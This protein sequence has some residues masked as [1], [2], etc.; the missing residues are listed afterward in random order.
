MKRAFS[1]RQRMTM[2]ISVFLI[3]LL[4]AFSFNIVYTRRASRRRILENVYT[5]T[6]F[7][8]ESITNAMSESAYSA[9]QMAAYLPFRSLSDDPSEWYFYYK[10]LQA[11]LNVLESNNF[12]YANIY[13][14]VYNL[15]QDYY[16]RSSIHPMPVREEKEM[17]SWLRSLDKYP[18]YT[19]Q[20][21]VFDQTGYFIYGILQEDFYIGVFLS[22]SSIQKLLARSSPK[23]TAFVVFDPAGA[24]VSADERFSF[25]E[26]GGTVP[27]GWFLDAPDT[28]KLG[29]ENYTLQVY[30]STYGFSVISAT[31][32]PG[33]L[34]GALSESPY[35][36]L[37]PGCLFL[38]VPI[39]Y[40]FLKQELIRPLNYL[41]F[42]FSR[43]ASGDLTFRGQQDMFSVEFNDVIAA[44]NSMLRQIRELRMNYYE[45]KILQ[46]QAENRY[47]RTISYPHFLLNNL[48]LINNFAYEKNEEGIHAAVMNLSSYLRYFITAD[49]SSHTLK[50]DVESARC[51]LN[52]NCLAYPD[53]ISYRFDAEED[54]LSLRFPPLI[55]STIVENCIKHGLMPG[56]ALSI[57]LVLKTINREEATGKILLFRAFNNGPAFPQEFLSMV[58]SSEMPP[59]DSTHIGLTGVKQ[60]LNTQ[61]GDHCLFRIMNDPDGVTVL[62]EVDMDALQ[63]N[64]EDGP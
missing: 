14:F 60:T 55:I 7:R 6:A 39:F 2:L 49:A 4:A 33:G 58:N 17:A 5:G 53:R 40:Y 13:Y 28:M 51:Y 3:A 16:L 52:L 37:V 47:L 43:V 26:S 11:T 64:G 44:F 15:K 10:D 35:L 46:Q 32:L 30:D 31:L 22:S 27:E 8:I 50:N 63:R 1:V 18:S 54:L 25:P 23:D 19:W 29:K 45:E 42:G 36:L 56:R 59:R 62:I 24:F 12:Q 21:K 57:D 61:F 38:F 34:Q 41:R 48:N 9:Q 20:T